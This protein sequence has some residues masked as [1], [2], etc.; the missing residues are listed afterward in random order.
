MQLGIQRHL[1][2]NDLR[3]PQRLSDG[4]Y[5]PEWLVARRWRITAGRF[6]SMRRVGQYQRLAKARGKLG[7]M[8]QLPTMLDAKPVK[9]I[10]CVFFPKFGFS[11]G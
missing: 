7:S 4:T 9:F 3:L 5:N 1:G 10:G 11:C 8:M 6:V 2:G